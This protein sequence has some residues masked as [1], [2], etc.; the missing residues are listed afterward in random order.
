MSEPRRK[1]DSAI[2]TGTMLVLL[3]VA[4]VAYV[5]GYFVLGE[6]VPNPAAA[7]PSYYRTFYNAWSARLYQPATQV[8]SCV[9]GQQVEA[10]PYRFCDE[11]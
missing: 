7:P 11:P 8:E 9:R 4:L 2:I 5:G 3:V 10:C 6:L 1:V